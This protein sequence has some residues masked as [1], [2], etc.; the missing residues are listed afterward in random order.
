MSRRRANGD[1]RDINVHPDFRLP[2]QTS[3]QSFYLQEI[4]INL[5]KIERAIAKWRR[6]PR[7]AD[8]LKIVQSAAFAVL[9]LSMIHGYDGVENMA[10]KLLQ[11]VTHLLRVRERYSSIVGAKLKAAVLTIRRVAEMEAE[12]ERQMTVENVNRQVEATQQDVKTRAA[13]LSES[14]E[15]IIMPAES[16]P[17]SATFEPPLF[18]IREN[19]IVYEL[20][21]TL[22]RRTDVPADAAAA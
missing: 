22:L 6:A 5:K 7:K 1:L 2:Q 13:Q 16:R 3:L 11:T 14:F 20:A 9:D 4:C 12:S 18:D 19:D 10:G 8:H 21:H 15:A 17:D